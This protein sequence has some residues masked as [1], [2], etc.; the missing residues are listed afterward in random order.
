[1]KLKILKNIELQN[2][3]QADHFSVLDGWRGLSILFV[4]AAH[5]LP[6]GPKAWRLNET[7]GL[8][9]MSLFFTLSGFLITNFLY[10]RPNVIDFLIRRFF[11]ILPLAWLYIIITLLI[12]SANKNTYLAHIFFYA[13]WPPIFLL[14]ETAHFWSLCVE[15]QFYMLIALFV[16]LFKKNGLL[17]F[18]LIGIFLTWY[19]IENGVYAAINTYYRGDEILAGC[20]LS[21]IYNNQLFPKLKNSLFKFPPYGLI[22]LLLLSC[23]SMGGFLNY[24]RPY[25]AAILVGVSLYG[26]YSYMNKILNLKFL[27]YIAAIS[28]A[29]YVIHGG[30][31]H[32]WLAEGEVLE[33]YAKRPLLFLVTFSL[34]HLSTYY[35]ESYFIKLGKNLSKKLY[36]AK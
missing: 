13:N 34:A 1:M 24:L 30:L 15:V 3:N 19:R 29:L 36:P 2:V 25:F 12:M 16:F 23:H 35:Y 32:T 7:A 9:G 20:F 28:Y 18:P 14:N 26:Q 31:M 10:K 8:L 22:V 11:R 21:L 6:L 5:L 27:F 4:L 33:K 17:F